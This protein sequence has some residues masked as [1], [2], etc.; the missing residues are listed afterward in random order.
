LNYS[1]RGNR[2]VTQTLAILAKSC[3]HKRLLLLILVLSLICGTALAESGEPS[4]VV[5]IINALGTSSTLNVALS[6]ISGSDVKVAF[7]L[8][9]PASS[10]RGVLSQLK[11]RINAPIIAATEFKNW[12]WFATSVAHENKDINALIFIAGIAVHKGKIKVINW[13]VW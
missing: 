10:V 13:S 6:Q 8:S 7:E 2:L 11:E 12:F 9:Y 3:V 1:G 4:D 5:P